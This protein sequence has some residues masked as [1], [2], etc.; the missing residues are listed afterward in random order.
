MSSQGE[1]DVL[2]AQV[3]NFKSGI[4]EIAHEINN[5]LGV[6]RMAAFLLETTDPDEA[7]RKHYVN[8]INTSV[9]RID[10]ALKRLRALRENPSPPDVATPQKP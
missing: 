3:T 1:L 8:L 6:L 2:Q 9:D 7:K 5:P 10:A 4:R